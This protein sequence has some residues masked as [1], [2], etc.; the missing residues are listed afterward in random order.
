MTPRTNHLGP[1]YKKYIFEYWSKLCIIFEFSTWNSNLEQTLMCKLLL[2]LE[3]NGPLLEFILP[4]AL[5][6]PGNNIL[7]KFSHLQ[8]L[9]L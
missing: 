5:A 3:W 9:E 2:T 4:I 1:R 8:L 6:G 7:L